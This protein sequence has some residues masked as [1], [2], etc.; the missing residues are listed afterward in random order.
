MAFTLKNPNLASFDDRPKVDA[1]LASPA[2]RRVSFRRDYALGHQLTVALDCQRNACAQEM[3]EEQL[4]LPGL[5]VGQAQAKM[6]VQ[7]FPFFCRH[8]LAI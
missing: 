3:E 2:A 1:L 8:S 7:I 6:P 5:E 4:E